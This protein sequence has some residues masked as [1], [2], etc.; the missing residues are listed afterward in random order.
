MTGEVSRDTVKIFL[1]AERRG[2]DSN[3]RTTSFI[4][5]VTKVGPYLRY[6]WVKETIMPLVIHW[7]ITDPAWLALTVADI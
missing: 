2:N 6:G 4:N 5:D 1:P 3:S 7:V